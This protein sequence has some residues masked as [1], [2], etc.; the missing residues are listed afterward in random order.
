M[1]D[2]IVPESVVSQSVVSQSV[3]PQKHR[4]V[5]QLKN[6]QRFFKFTTDDK[7]I[8]FLHIEDTFAILEEYLKED[9]L[10]PSDHIRVIDT[11]NILTDQFNQGVSFGPV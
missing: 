8:N 5:E 10:H 4:T 2:Q 6:L 3:V 11:M 9:C 7:F 1:Q